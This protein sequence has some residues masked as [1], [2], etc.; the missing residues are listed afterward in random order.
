MHIEP[1]AEIRQ[2][3]N[4]IAELCRSTREPVCL[5]TNGEADLVV[6]DVE[7]FARRGKMPQ[8]RE[9]L[10]AVEEDRAAG[11]M[12]CAPDDLDAS[13]DDIINKAEHGKDIEI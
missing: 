1:S 2:R 6:M 12:G 9:E 7:S 4:E 8:L 13:L 5:T 10:L 11:R 3:Y